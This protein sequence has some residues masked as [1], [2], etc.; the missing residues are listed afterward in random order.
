MHRKGGVQLGNGGDNGNGSAGTFYEGVMTS[1]YPTHTTHNAVQA[2]IVAARYDMQ[3]VSLSRITTFTPGSTQEVTEI[4]TNTTGVPVKDITLTIPAPKGWKSIVLGSEET[5]KKFTDPVAPGGSVSAT[6][7]V[8]SSSTTGAGILNGRAE[9]KNQTTGLKQ[10]ETSSRRVRNVLPIK[11][12]EVRLE[13]GINSTNQFIELYNAGNSDID[14]SNWNLIHTQS[15][16]APVKLATIPAGTKLAAHGFYLLGLAGSGL[17]SP[18]GRGEKIIN[19]RSITGFE[20]GQKIDIDGETRTIATVG[21]AAYPMAMVFVPVSTGPWFIIPPGSTN[22][23]VT[24]TAGFEVGDKIGID[25][26]GNFE[27]AT[28]TAVGKAA[29][30]T[31]LAVA[32]K[33]GENIIKVAANSNITVGDMLTI[34]TGARKEVVG[35]KRIIN[36]AEAPSRGGFDTG[37]S[38]N[39]NTGDVELTEPLRFDHMLAVDVSDIGTGISFSPAT[40]FE[41]KSGDAVQAL[42]SG[43]TLESALEKSHDSGTAV[44]NPLDMSVG[45]QGSARPNQWY[46]AVLSPIAGSIALMDASGMVVVDAMVYGSR[47]SNSSANG[48]ITSPEIATLEG[49]QNQGGCIVVVP[50]SVSGFGQFL[51]S[52]GKTDRSAGRFPDGADCDNNCLDFMLQNTITLAALVTAGSVNIKV[53]SVADFTIGQ[54]IIIDVDTKSETA[55][56]TT[57]GTP[58]AT[59]VGTATN[60]G[61]KA[62]PVT[63]V[64]G[65]GTGQTITIDNGINQETAVVATVAAGRRRFGSR[66]VIPTDSII[67]TMPLKYEHTAGAQISGSGITLSRPLTMAHDNGVQVAGNIPTPG[68]PNKYIRKP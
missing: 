4:F 59:T 33:A 3:R 1:G 36:V 49:D 29:T 67:L 47:Q 37:G 7:S 50:G 60:A 48:I 27:V 66:T 62:I 43:I 38:G 12:N 24:N 45:Y 39:G 13:T 52:A 44:L 53:N 30:L 15:M 35:V 19:V 10:F 51:P 58:G 9:W 21:T 54:K 42:G 57:I 34:N 41:H 64:E 40:R 6:F 22:L 16:W 55:V 14:L 56:I 23:P 17:V 25:P 20:A 8:T 65:F 2:N 28:V 32:A 5:S 63:G 46:G 61:A 68:E 26:G 31:T 18:A 11:I